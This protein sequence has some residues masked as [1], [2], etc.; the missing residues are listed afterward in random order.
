ML[1]ADPKLQH[2]NKS[3]TPPV[4]IGAMK[5]Q[6]HWDTIYLKFHDLH[7]VD[8]LH[9]WTCIPFCSASIQAKYCNNFTMNWKWT[10]PNSLKEF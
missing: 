7:M 3:V 9:H 6:T 2:G 10:I 5:L 8:D 4:P 1:A